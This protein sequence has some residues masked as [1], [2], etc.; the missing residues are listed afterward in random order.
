LPKARKTLSFYPSFFAKSPKISVL[1][2]ILNGT[3]NSYSY[4]IEDKYHIG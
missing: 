1:L 4:L 3:L 2:K